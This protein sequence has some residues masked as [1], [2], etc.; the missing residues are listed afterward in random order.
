MPEHCHH[1]LAALLLV[2]AIAGRAQVRLAASL[3]CPATAEPATQ[4]RVALVLANTSTSPVSGRLTLTFSHSA[5]APADDPSVQFSTGGRTA[6]VTLPAGGTRAEAALQ[7]GTVAGSIRVTATLEAGGVDVTPAPPP[8]CFI[9]VP[10]RAPA[11]T[12]VQVERTGTGFNVFV[13]GYSTPRS[14]LEARFR[15]LP[16][17]GYPWEPIEVILPAETLGTKF[18]NWYR[19]GASAQYGSQFTLLQPFAADHNV[20]TIGS[21]YVS[22]RNREGNSAEQSAN[23]P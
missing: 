8:A 20:H 15:F 11:I 4:P 1:R 17:S 5:D 23:F 18:T 3:E 2:A 13:S 21:V 14:M 22:L 19:D 9:S 12:S 7:S 10:R 16:K 6:S